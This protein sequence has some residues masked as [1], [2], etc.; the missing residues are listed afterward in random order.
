MTAGTTTG[1]GVI[2][3][4]VFTDQPVVG[5]QDFAAP[6]LDHGR[7]KVASVPFANFAAPAAG[8][9]ATTIVYI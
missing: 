7:V 5:T 4:H 8:K 2:A 1:A 6:L 3:G 9:N